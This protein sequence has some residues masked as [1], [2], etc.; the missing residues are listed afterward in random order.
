MIKIFKRYN[1]SGQ[2]ICPMCRRLIDKDYL[3]EYCD[4]CIRDI[5]EAELDEYD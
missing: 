3:L 2:R 4:F 1:E 5:D